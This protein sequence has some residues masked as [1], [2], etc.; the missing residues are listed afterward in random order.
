MLQQQTLIPEEERQKESLKFEDIKGHEHE[1]RAAEVAAAGGHN[2]L[3][4]GPAGSGKTTLAHAMQSI[5]TPLWITEETSGTTQPDF[6]ELCNRT[7]FRA[8][9]NSIPCSQMIGEGKHIRQGEIFLA[10]GGGLLMDDL[11]NYKPRVLESLRQSLTQRSISVNSRDRTVVFPACFLLIATMQLCPCGNLGDSFRPCACKPEAVHK[12]QRRVPR[13]LLQYFDLVVEVCPVPFS[14]LN[15]ERECESSETVR[16]RVKAVRS[17]TLE[18]LRGKTINCNAEMEPGD[19]RK[20]CALDETSKELMK[21]GMQHLML[22]AGAYFQVLKV[23]RTI[24]DLAGAESL[25]AAHVAEALQ[26]QKKGEWL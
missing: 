21:S 13:D 20:F 18:R 12:Y 3:L 10:N 9:Q 8:P 25:T 14:K 6:G 17:L 15:D 11:R 23:A 7:P 26:Y 24:A 22:T 4:I 16:A 5:L 1:K 2:I 19:V